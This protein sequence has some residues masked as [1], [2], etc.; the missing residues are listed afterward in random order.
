MH[1]KI[2]VPIVLVAIT[3]TAGLAWVWARQQPAEDPDR[4]TLYGNVD[5]RQV[6]L[7][8]NGS[9]RIDSLSA[10]EG[11]S[12]RAGQVLGRLNTTAARLRLAQAQAQV[13]EQEQVSRRLQQAAQ[14]INRLTLLCGSDPGALNGR[15]MDDLAEPLSGSLPD[16]RMGLPSDVA[17]RRP[18]VAAAEARLR[19]RGCAPRP[20]ASASPR[21]TSIPASRWAQASAT[22]PWTA[23]P[24]PR[25]ARGSGAWARA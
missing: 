11:D 17:R 1:P 23:R 24:S 16:L 20:P 13:G 15:L 8:F 2:L 7:A 25:G 12:V 21:P 9:D 6:A 18:D 5:I 3:V 22:R 10:R 14:A 4:L 19:R